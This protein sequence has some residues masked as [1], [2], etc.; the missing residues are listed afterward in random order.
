MPA[1]SV[2]PKVHSQLDAYLDGLRMLAAR[3]LSEAQVRQRLARRGHSGDDIDRAVA[4]LREARAIDDDRVAEAIARR[5]TAVRRRGRL[6]A[7]QQIERAGID[8]ATA[9]RA[10]D[11]VFS[12]VDADD[13][14]EA[15]LGKGLRG[16]T[17]IGTDAEFRRL[18]RY[19]VGQGFEPQRVLDRLKQ[20]RKA[21]D[22]HSEEPE[23]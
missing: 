17:R 9:R 19:L 2:K 11:E 18:Y 10:L 13:L 21:H 12:T 16:R 1:Q 7:R 8:A 23:E 20:N 4:R 15:A 6:R 22:A 3:E 5:E 14:L